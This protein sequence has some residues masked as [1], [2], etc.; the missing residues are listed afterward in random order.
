MQI[1]D[2][3]VKE[4]VN[5]AGELQAIIRKDLKGGPDMVYVTRVATT[6]DLVELI[7]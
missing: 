5:E 2:N 7:K 3:S 1:S 4:V 6:D